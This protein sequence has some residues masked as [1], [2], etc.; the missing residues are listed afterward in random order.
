MS[1]IGDE[2]LDL[3]VLPI[4]DNFTMGPDDA[5]QAVS[6]LRPK[7]VVPV[8]YNTWSV[9]EQDAEWWKTR[10]EERTTAL[11]HTLTPG[12]SVRT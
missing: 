1:L 5:L 2:G 3:A 7:K 8:H 6:L 10:V 4:G 11:V 9:I 12:E